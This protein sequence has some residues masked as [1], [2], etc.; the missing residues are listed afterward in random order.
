MPRREK[1]ISLEWALHQ[2]RSHSA[3]LMKMCAPGEP[4][5]VAW[6]VVPGGR[7]D[8]KTARK[9]WERHDV[10]EYDDGL[11]PGNP[12]SWRIGHHGALSK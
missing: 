5:G 3:R 11:F 7:V 8:E 2:M 12:Q 1:P 6:F 10:F 9:I 4:G